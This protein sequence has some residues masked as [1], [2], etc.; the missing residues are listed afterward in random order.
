[1]EFI[2][3]VSLLYICG[4]M[5]KNCKILDDTKFIQNPIINFETLLSPWQLG[6]LYLKG[7]KGTETIQRNRLKPWGLSKAFQKCRT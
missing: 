4:K 3:H 7:F 5:V 6:I 2:N 1:M